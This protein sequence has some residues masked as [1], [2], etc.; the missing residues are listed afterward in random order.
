MWKPPC[1]PRNPPRMLPRSAM[2]AARELPVRLPGPL[3]GRCCIIPGRIWGRG[4]AWGS[5]EAAGAFAAGGGGACWAKAREVQSTMDARG[6]RDLEIAREFI[7][8][9]FPLV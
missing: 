3:S 9:V 8:L 1:S 6:I 2:A 7:G 4:W 5:A